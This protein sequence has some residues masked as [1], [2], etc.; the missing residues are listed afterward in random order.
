VNGDKAVF[1]FGKAALPRRV[2]QVSGGRVAR[3]VWIVLAT[4]LLCLPLGLSN[5]TQFVVN[6]MLVY[7]LVALGFNVIIGYLGQLAF[8][9][10]A[11]FGAGAYAA[12][13]AMA[14]FGLPFPAAIVA[15]ALVGALVGTL[16]GLPALRVRSHYLVIITLAVGELLR[17]FYVHADAITYG[18]GGFSLP[19]LSWFGL[20]LSDR[21]KYYVFL[22]CVA[23]GIGA[24]SA[25]MRS[26]YGRAFAAVRNNEQA[27]ASLGIA[28]RRTKVLAFAWSGLIVGIAGGL[29]ALLNGRVS[30]ESFGLSQVL[31]HFAI[32]MI[33]GLASVLGS[34]LGAVL[35]TAAPELLRNL[36]GME[37][38]VFSVLL[39]IVLFFMPRGLGG[40]IADR[41][42]MLRERLYRGDRD[43]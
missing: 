35:L 2:A 3:L 34:V 21:G 15:S 22:T 13:L 23:L 30:P 33:G 6:T 7:C 36:P 25:L 8:A 11:F 43:A 32:V 29:F 38:I 17:W 27:A 12:G 18:A 40:L 1:E 41:V 4:A 31:F 20:A 5:Y 10:A 14:R 26:R 37:E 39:I 9:S 42:P 24:T 16:V 19:T 28:V